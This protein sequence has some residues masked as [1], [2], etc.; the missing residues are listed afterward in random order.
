MYRRPTSGRHLRVFRNIM[1][2]FFFDSL[3]YRGP[4]S[5]RHWRLFRNSM[6][7]VLFLDCF[8][9]VYRGPVSGRHWRLF[10]NNMLVVLFLKIVFFS[11]SRTNEW[12]AMTPVYK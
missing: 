6:L 2:V 7:V 12:K 4:M 5:G 8:S 9:L 3:L 11:V 1:L 10:R